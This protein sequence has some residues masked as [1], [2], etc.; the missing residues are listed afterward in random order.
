MKHGAE[1]KLVAVIRFKKLLG[2]ASGVLFN[3]DCGCRSR[4]KATDLGT[5]VRIFMLSTVL[6]DIRVVV[7]SSML[8]GSMVKQQ[9]YGALSLECSKA[10]LL[11]LLVG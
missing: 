5:F 11:A 7:R 10:V 8:R 4:D 1:D 9:T 6:A 2:D 3:F